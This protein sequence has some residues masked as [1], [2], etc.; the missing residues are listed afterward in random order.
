MASATSPRSSTT[1]ANNPQFSGVNLVPGTE[2]FDPNI[3]G[4]VLK[5]LKLKGVGS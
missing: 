3:V 1:W 5:G 4:A 2:P